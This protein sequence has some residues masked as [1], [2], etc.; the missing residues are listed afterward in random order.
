[1]AKGVGSGSGGEQAAD[2]LD[3]H[4]AG[5]EGFDGVDDMAPQ[6]GSGAGGQSGAGSGD[7]EVLAGEAGGEDAHGLG[8]VPVDGLYIAQ[9]GH[10]PVAGEDL[11]G[12]WVGLGVPGDVAAECGLDAQVQ[13]ADSGEQ[14]ADR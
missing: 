4:Q 7:R 12:V 11:G 8:L 13:A 10:L 3:H 14:A 9:V 2:I 6:A 1:M 5:V